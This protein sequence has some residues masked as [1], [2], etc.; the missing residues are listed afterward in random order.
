MR[1]HG[2]LRS[3]CT[4]R[5]EQPLKWSDGFAGAKDPKDDINFDPSRPMLPRILEQLREEAEEN[6]AP[7]KPR[8]ASGLAKMA[9]S[10][11]TFGPDGRAPLPG[12]LTAALRGL[13]IEH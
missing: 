5:R 1:E 4:G 9:S 13:S 12:H 10:P 6:E 3:E 8:R 11:C 2:Q 7:N